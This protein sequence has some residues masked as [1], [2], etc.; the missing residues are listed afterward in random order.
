MLP[1][2]YA[3]DRFTSIDCALAAEVSP[4]DEAELQIGRSIPAGCYTS[5][6]WQCL[7]FLPEPHGHTSLR[8]TLPHVAGSAGSRWMAG[9]A[10]SAVSGGPKSRNVGAK[11]PAETRMRVSD[12]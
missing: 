11:S 9:S 8:P 3:E 2:V 7:Y 1:R 4:A 5:T 12:T 10:A 6:P